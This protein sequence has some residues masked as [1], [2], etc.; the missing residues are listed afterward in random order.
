MLVLERTAGR[1][2]GCSF[3]IGENIL[4]TVQRT[5]GRKVWI[6]IDAPADLRILRD[7]AKNREA[8]ERKET[9]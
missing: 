5:S 4:I 2:L 6:G 1:E 3:T 8:R 7:D 9:P